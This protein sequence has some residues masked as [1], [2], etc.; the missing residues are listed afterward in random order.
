M[1]AFVASTDRRRA[2]LTNRPVSVVTSVTAADVERALGEALRGAPVLVAAGPADEATVASAV[3]TILIDA[4][5]SSEAPAAAPIA[6][7]N[8]GRT[9]V[10]NAPEA[11]VAIV[12]AAF[13]APTESA[14]L[15]AALT[16]LV[17]DLNAR[18]TQSLRKELG[19]T[20]GFGVRSYP[21]LPGEQILTIGG[22]VPPERASEV[23]DV[24]RAEI[25]ALREGGVTADELKITKETI[26]QQIAQRNAEPGIV[27]GLAVDYHLR[28]LD[29]DLAAM[30]NEVDALTLEVVSAALPDLLPERATAIIVTPNPSV[31][32]ADCTVDV[33]EEAANCASD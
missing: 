32:Q 10:V 33:P 31:V 29:R 20:Y 27:A 16:A 26:S 6:L 13:P 21:L 11:E 9:L 3:D 14:P 19:A 12:L 25:A 23:L 5:P 8:E 1:A 2:A 7:T 4:P 18:L 17:G 22:V 15:S 30:R 24:L 28:G